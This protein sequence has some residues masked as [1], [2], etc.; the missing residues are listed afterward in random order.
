MSLYQ[1][2]KAAL[3]PRTMYMRRKERDMD[4][5]ARPVFELN[6][7]RKPVYEFT[8]ATMM[9][10][11]ILYDVPI[12]ETATVFDV[13]A[14]IGEW[15]EKVWNRYRPTIY[16]F[17]PAPGAHRQVVAKFGDN[18]KVHTFP[19]GLGAADTT[20]SLALAA[21][22]SSIYDDVGAMGTVDVEIRDVAAV[23]DELGLERLT[24]LK[25]NIEGGEYDLFDRLDETGWLPRID[26]VLVQFH[27]WHPKAYGRRRRNRKAF[28]RSHDEVWGWSWVWE[29]W[30]R[31][32]L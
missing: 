28:A 4:P 30:R 11:A 12:D 20:A 8:G 25:V 26:H 9:N 1:L 17:E 13:G 15:S 6:Y 2:K 16:T 21:A 18:D 23:L 3:T 5:M 31:K 29:Y 14:Y 10:P 7:Y 27:E 24:V 32:G 22:G 19:Y